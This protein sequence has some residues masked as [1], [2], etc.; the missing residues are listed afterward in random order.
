ML[1]RPRLFGRKTQP[2]ITS[3]GC[4]F[5]EY[6]IPGALSCRDFIKIAGISS[7]LIAINA[8]F[9]CS[10]P[11][12]TS[13][14]I[15][16]PIFIRGASVE[17]AIRIN[18]ELMDK[19]EK[20]LKIHKNMDTL[21][22]HT[23]LST[24]PTV[25]DMFKEPTKIGQFVTD[26]GVLIDFGI[27][28][29]G[30][31]IINPVS[32]VDSRI[33]QYP[34]TNKLTSYTKKEFNSAPVEVFSSVARQNRLI[35]YGAAP[36]NDFNLSEQEVREFLRGYFDGVNV[37]YRT[38]H[39]VMGDTEIK[40]NKEGK[41]VQQLT[42]VSPA[43]TDMSIEI[44]TSVLGRSTAMQP[45]LDRP[46]QT[47]EVVI[48]LPNIHRLS[49]KY[50]INPK[51]LLQYALV[52]EIFDSS[53]V[54]PAMSFKEKLKEFVGTAYAQLVIADPNSNSVY[55]DRFNSSGPFVDKLAAIMLQLGR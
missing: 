55:A 4:S 45:I 47:L 41:D 50:G 51:R 53:L 23:A 13:V 24:I 22:I 12:Q 21:G 11:P 14:P 9:G 7:L 18:T 38:L 27:Q 3:T 32:M 28:E 2:V 52:N 15:P 8:L 40:K 49:V 26:G 20:G 34:K 33:V 43:S 30:E 44:G 35:L 29:N 42:L 36:M 19:L 46:P 25:Q 1:E 5:G 17:D 6:S 39:I 10:P 31:P 16:T 37:P 48:H 54:R